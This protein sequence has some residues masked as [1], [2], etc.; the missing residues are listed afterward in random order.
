MHMA[1]RKQESWYFKVTVACDFL[2]SFFHHTVPPSPIRIC[3]KPFIYKKKISWSYWS[4]KM[5]PKRPGHREIPNF[6]CTRHWWFMG[7]TVMFNFLVSG[8]P[9][10]AN[11][12]CLGHWESQFPV[13]RTPVNC[14][15]PMSLSLV[16]CEMPMSG[17]AWKQELPVSRTPASGSLIVFFYKL[18][19]I[20]TDFK[21]T[22]YKKVK[23]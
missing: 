4:F 6:Q 14:K 2:V 23:I 13:S 12:R 19:A 11:C 17:T 16:K 9:G 20:D 21:A 15:L 1:I 22:T 7:F 5:F 10:I 18:Q 8:T 3:L